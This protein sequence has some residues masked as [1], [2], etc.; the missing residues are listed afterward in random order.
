[1]KVVTSKRKAPCSDQESDCIDLTEME[2]GGG[3]DL[4]G[5]GGSAEGGS[6][7]AEAA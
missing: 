6:S 1:M 2:L 7:T 4:E 5:G 3:V